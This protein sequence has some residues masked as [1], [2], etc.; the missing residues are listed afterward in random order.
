MKKLCI[1]RRRWTFSVNRYNL[2]I[3]RFLYLVS[4]NDRNI[5]CEK[6]ALK[7]SDVKL[8]R[9]FH[10]LQNIIFIFAKIVSLRGITYFC[11]CLALPFWFWWYV[12]ILKLYQRT[13]VSGNVIVENRECILLRTFRFFF[14]LARI[15]FFR[16]SRMSSSFL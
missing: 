5:C 1:K 15:F 4:C 6:L 2:K 12:L 8:T 9:I 14:F 16:L 13:K 10:E 3:F 7:G 11:I